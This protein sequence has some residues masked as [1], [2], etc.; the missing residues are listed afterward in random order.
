MK[1]F[2]VFNRATQILVSTPGIARL[3]SAHSKHEG[4]GEAREIKVVHSEAFPTGLSG[5]HN[6]TH[7]MLMLTHNEVPSGILN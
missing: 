6:P 2:D 4:K 3:A 1:Q 5:W 7:L